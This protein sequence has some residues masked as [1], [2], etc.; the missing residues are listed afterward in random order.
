MSGGVKEDRDWWCGLARASGRRG[1]A[2]H[3]ALL[4]FENLNHKQSIVYFWIQQ[5]DDGKVEGKAAPG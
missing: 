1:E 5:Y 3:A 2:D 4:V